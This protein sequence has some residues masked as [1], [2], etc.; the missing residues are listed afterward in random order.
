MEGDDLNDPVADGM[1]SILD[2]HI[3]LSRRLAEENQYPAVD[4]LKSISRLMPDIV[5][6]EKE[7]LAKAFREILATYSRNEDVINIGA[8]VKGSNP[9][10]DLALE[11]INDCKGYL[12]Q[13]LNQ[14]VGV[15]QSFQELQAIVAKAGRFAKNAKPAPAKP[16]AAA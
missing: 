12:I 5:P 1:R 6:P 8:Y 7:A 11:M 10:I 16:A 13:G 9:R 14:P 3:V 2:G 15:E 4:V